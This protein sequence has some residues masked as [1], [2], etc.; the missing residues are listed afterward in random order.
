MQTIFAILAI[1]SS[2]L[3]SN[4][5]KYILRSEPSKTD[6]YIVTIKNTPTRNGD[7]DFFFNVIVRNISVKP[8]ITKI[9]FG[10]CTFSSDLGTR[11]ASGGDKELTNAILPGDE[12]SLDFHFI[13]MWNY[14]V[15][16]SSGKQVCRDAKDFKLRSC[17]VAISNN[18]DDATD[19]PIN[20]VF[21]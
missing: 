8:F 14:C 13:E 10:E 7:G 18:T 16:D 21:P 12:A 15:Y 9:H 2:F 1:L 11:E 20:A 4:F 5:N 19:L 3:A 6:Q 17:K